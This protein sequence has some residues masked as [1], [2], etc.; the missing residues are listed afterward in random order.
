MIDYQNLSPPFTTYQT[1]ICILVSFVCLFYSLDQG[2]CK[3]TYNN[4]YFHCSP[5]DRPIGTLRVVT[6]R[7]LVVLSGSSMSHPKSVRR[8]RHL[9]GHTSRGRHTVSSV[10]EREINVHKFCP[11]GNRIS[12]RPFGRRTLYLL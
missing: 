3:K 4:T 7:K 9:R 10:E 6:A 11:S 12:N 5:R 8:L 1:N 2:Q